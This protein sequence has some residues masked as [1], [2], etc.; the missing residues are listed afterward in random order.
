MLINEQFTDMDTS[1]RDMDRFGMLGLLS[2]LSFTICS[3]RHLGMSLRKI[4]MAIS[5]FV[6]RS[7]NVVWRWEKKLKGFRDTLA[8][9]CIV[10]IYL[11]DDRKAWIIVAY[12]PLQRKLLGIWLTSEKKDHVIAFFLNELVKRFGKHPVYTDGALYYES[13]CRILGLEHQVYTFG[14]WLHTVI[15]SIICT[16]ITTSH[17]ERRYV[18]GNMYGAG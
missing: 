1:I 15:E 12:E 18:F 3:L 5:P 13:A 8:S 7:Y 16:Q 10:S 9:K 11:V 17:V 14:S 4:A 2:L 6:S